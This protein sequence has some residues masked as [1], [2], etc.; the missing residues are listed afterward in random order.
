MVFEFT[1]DPL[2]CYCIT[3]SVSWVP[4]LC[5]TCSICGVERSTAYYVALGGDDSETQLVHAID[6]G[7]IDSRT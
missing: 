7:F 4:S 3:S 5:P 2:F 6:P 1:S